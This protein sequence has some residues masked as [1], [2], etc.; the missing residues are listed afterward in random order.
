MKQEQED[1]E[2][3]A[4]RENEGTWEQPAR[5]Y[6][7]SLLARNLLCADK[8]NITNYICRNNQEQII[9]LQRLIPIMWRV[10]LYL[11]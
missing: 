6:I 1:A 9:F 4:D 3:E 2:A 5:R 8:L 11:I 7:Q 10:Y